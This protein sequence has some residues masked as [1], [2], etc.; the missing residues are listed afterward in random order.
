MILALAASSKAETFFEEE[1]EDGIKINK[2]YNVQEEYE[3]K[4]VDDTVANP[5]KNNQ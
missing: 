5:I 1:E 4:E 2:V 3:V